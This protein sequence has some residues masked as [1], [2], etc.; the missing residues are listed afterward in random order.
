[1]A[2]F[3]IESSTDELED[4]G[5]PDHE[6][7]L[8]AKAATGDA[9]EGIVAPR[10]HV[11]AADEW[12]TTNLEQHLGEPHDVRIAREVPDVYPDE[13]AY[14]DPTGEGSE[15]AG[16]LVEPDEGAREDTEKDVVAYDAGRDSEGFT[17]EEAAMHVR[18]EG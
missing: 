12:G 11:L 18:H 13:L 4:E 17:A 7:P 3:D 14:A 1:M 8:R 6:G 9:Q 16:R 5:I 10:D 15:P 2:D